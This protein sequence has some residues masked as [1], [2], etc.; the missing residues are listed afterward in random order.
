MGDNRVCEFGRKWNPKTPRRDI[1]YIVNALH[2]AAIR[3]QCGD[4]AV[5]VHHENQ[6]LFSRVTGGS[7]KV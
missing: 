1:R 3:K 4:Y 5:F 7:F 6:K 2:V